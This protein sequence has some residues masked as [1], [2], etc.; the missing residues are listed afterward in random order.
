MI[1]QQAQQDGDPFHRRECKPDSRHAKERG[2][3]TGRGCDSDKTSK[4][5]NGKGITRLFRRTEICCGQVI[6]PDKQ[7]TE[8]IEG[9]SVFCQRLEKDVF[10]SVETLH[11]FR[12]KDICQGKY[13]NS[14]DKGQDNAFAVKL[15]CFGG[16]ILSVHFTD[17]GLNAVGNAVYKRLYHPGEVGYDSVCGDADRSRGPEDEKVEYDK[18]DSGRQLRDKG[19]ESG[20]EDLAQEGGGGALQADKAKPVFL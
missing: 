8:K 16:F 18:H 19:G 7:E 5:R 1:H 17:Q 14:D 13:E 3:Q 6:I 15:F 10:F 9:Q 20:G 11:Q 2:Q 12:G 4:Q